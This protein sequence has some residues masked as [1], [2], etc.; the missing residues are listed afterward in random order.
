MDNYALIEMPAG[1][2]DIAPARLTPMQMKILKG[3]QSGRLNKQIAFDLGIAEATVK[4]HMT[5]LMRKLH[6]RNRTQ[7]ALAAQSLN[8]RAG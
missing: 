8:R 2:G 5:A 1:D 6:V 4:A 3:V 7:V